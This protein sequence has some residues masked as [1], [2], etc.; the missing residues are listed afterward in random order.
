M[1]LYKCNQCKK[2]IDSW[3]N[4]DSL[5]LSGKHWTIHLC[6]KCGNGIVA[7]LK[8]KKLITKTK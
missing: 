6:A 5:Y 8:R 1:V 3:K 4:D 2:E 7:A